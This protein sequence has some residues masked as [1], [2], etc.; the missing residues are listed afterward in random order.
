[1]HG[2]LYSFQF[3][4]Y[5]KCNHEN[6]VKFLGSVQLSLHPL[7]IGLLYE[8]CDSGNLASFIKDAQEEPAYTLS[9]FPIAQSLALDMLS[10]ICYLHDN[11]IIHRDMKPENV[12][13]SNQYAIVSSM[14]IVLG[15]CFL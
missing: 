4:F 12:L 5:R 10:G 6:I 2:L 7:K 9:G 14:T 13:V 8:W 11:G 1:M 15:C 3:L